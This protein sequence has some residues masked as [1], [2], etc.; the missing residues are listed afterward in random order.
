MGNQGFPWFAPYILCP[1]SIGMFI[2]EILGMGEVL[3]LF[4]V[5]AE[6][7]GDGRGI[8]Q[9]LHCLGMFLTVLLYN[10]S[11]AVMLKA[12]LCMAV[13]PWLIEELE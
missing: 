12:S 6:L 5:P 2:M 4:S 8:E 11:A 10:L 7:V 3:K 9:G 1:I 13:E